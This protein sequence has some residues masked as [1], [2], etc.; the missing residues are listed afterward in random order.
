[1]SCCGNPAIL[2]PP[3]PP[4]AIGVDC[5]RSGYV[6]QCIAGV[7]TWVLALHDCVPNDQ[8]TGQLSCNGTQCVIEQIGGCDVLGAL[9]PPQV[10]F[11]A[12][13]CC[14]PP[15][16]GVGGGSGTS[17][18][19]ESPPTYP[20]VYPPSPTPPYPTAQY[21]NCIYTSTWNCNTSSWS[22][23]ALSGACA[24]GAANNNTPWGYNGTCGALTIVSASGACGP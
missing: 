7:D 12:P 22:S 17:T 20:P 21:C 19:Y 6:C 15:G 23:P 5:L 2:P 9:P 3:P 10:P 16:G 14:T 8:C 24:A 4:V 18:V 1:M 13:T 11:C